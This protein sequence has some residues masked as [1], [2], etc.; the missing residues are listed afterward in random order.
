MGKRVMKTALE[1]EQVG[2]E[3]TAVLSRRQGPWSIGKSAFY[4]LRRVNRPRRLK[5]G[6]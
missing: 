3:K 4:T 1:E 2:K 5:F 6:G